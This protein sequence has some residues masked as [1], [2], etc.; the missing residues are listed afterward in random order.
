MGRE[1]R[2]PEEVIGKL[3]EAEVLIAKGATV[4]EASKAIGAT[5]QTHDRSRRARRRPRSARWPCGGTGRAWRVSDG[6]MS[7]YLVRCRIIRKPRS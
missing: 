7:Y 5:G 3:R 4:P 2:G 1:R 6:A